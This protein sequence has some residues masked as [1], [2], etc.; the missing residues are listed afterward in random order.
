M[1][2]ALVVGGAGFIGCHLTGA[3]LRGHH[4]VRV[5]DDLSTGS[6]RNVR[7]LARQTALEGDAPGPRLDFI[8][9]D[10]RDRD[11]VRKAVR[12]ADYVFHHAAHPILVRSPRNPLDVMAVDVDGLLNVLWASRAEG[13]RRVIYASCRTVYGEPPALPLREDFPLDPRSALGASK[14]AGEAFCR[15]YWTAYGLETACLRYFNVYGPC[16]STSAAPGTVVTR[17][18]TALMSGVPPVVEGD[19]EQTRDFVFVEDAVCATIAAATGADVAGRSVNV[20]S[21][22][23]CSI[24]ELLRTLTA[25][26]GIDIPPRFLP[27]A[28]GGITHN[29]ADTTLAARLL[30]WEARVPLVEGLRR[31]FDHFRRHREAGASGGRIAAPAPPARSA[32]RGRGAAPAGRCPARG[33]LPH[34]TAGTALGG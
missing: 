13:V 21:G 32:G 11:L 34:L 6:L 3:L 7:I 23:A 31:T 12:G 22:R 14:A 29:V 10:V 28:P 20:G 9:G 27:A 8:L 1:A 24:S 17:F 30:R 5:L 16:Q 25:V 19:G 33:R 2:M 26:T 18:L 4:A 15:A